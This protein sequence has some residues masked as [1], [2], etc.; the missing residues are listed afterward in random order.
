MTKARTIDYLA[1]QQ[2]CVDCT[3]YYRKLSATNYSSPAACASSFALLKRYDRLMMRIRF[4]GESFSISKE[5]FK[6]LDIESPET[7][8]AAIVKANELYPRLASEF[9][10]EPTV[11]KNREVVEESIDNECEE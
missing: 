6:R 7:L 5:L 8:R 3:H 1:L 4:A 11:K 9:K 2:F 10:M